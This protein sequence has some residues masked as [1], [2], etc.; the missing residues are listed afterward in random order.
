MRQPH[1]GPTAPS[2]CPQGW[3]HTHCWAA[4][5]LALRQ[6]Q[7]SAGPQPPSFSMCS[8]PCLPRSQL[9][10]HSL[11]S[12][13]HAEP[14]LLPTAPGTSTCSAGEGLL[15]GHKRCRAGGGTAA[16]GVLQWDSPSHSLLEERAGSE[17]TVEPRFTA[18]KQ[19]V[20]MEFLLFNATAAACPVTTT[21]RSGAA[22]GFPSLIPS[23][24]AS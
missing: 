21:S 18:Y 14:R 10:P 17:R 19:L 4:P 1:R 6:S 20:K 5:C 3:Y 22:A 9:W 16:L 23:D 15:W 24:R 13:T 8:E 7:S 11:P 12:V 2:Q